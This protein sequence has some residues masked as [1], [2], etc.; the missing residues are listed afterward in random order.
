VSVIASS[1][2]SRI[3]FI[4]GEV[5]LKLVFSEFVHIQS[6]VKSPINSDEY[7]PSKI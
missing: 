5:V 7:D 1:V 2:T 4:M 6:N 3:F